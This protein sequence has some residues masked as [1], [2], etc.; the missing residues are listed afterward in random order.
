ML[1]LGSRKL[2][3]LHSFL[4]PTIYQLFDWFYNRNITKSI[5]DLNDLVVHILLAPDFDQEHQERFDAMWELDWLDKHMDDWWMAWRLCENTA[6]GNKKEIQDW[7]KGTSIWSWQ[8]SLSTP[9]PGHC[10]CVSRAT[11]ELDVTLKQPLLQSSCILTP[12]TL[13]IS[14]QHPYGQSVF[15]SKTSPN[16]FIW[17]HFPLKVRGLKASEIMNWIWL[18]GVARLVTRWE[19]GSTRAGSKWLNNAGLQLRAGLNQETE[20]DEEE[21]NKI[22]GTF[23]ISRIR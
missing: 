8:N 3:L 13:Q 5:E 4:N 20:T 17:C 1:A 14:P 18:W 11:C 15:T 2:F 12:H 23:V 6:S 16:T 7:G 22:R 19:Q 21:R 9:N 10:V